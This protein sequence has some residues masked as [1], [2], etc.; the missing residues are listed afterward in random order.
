[1]L[2]DEGDY[3]ILR[4]NY[5]LQG[6][7]CDASTFAAE[8]RKAN[9]KFG[10]N[11]GKK[12]IKIYHYIVSFDPKDKLASGLAIEETQELCM[13]FVAEHFPGHQMLVC[14]HGDGHNGTGNIHVHIVL[15]S[16]RIQDVEP[17]LY[18]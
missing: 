11:K 16:L 2:L 13:A 6:I 14:A 18:K 10:K 1:M 12:E 8:S 5:I 3:P 17:L 9:R 7:N 15:N 4:E